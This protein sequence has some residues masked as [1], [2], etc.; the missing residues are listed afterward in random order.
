MPTQVQRT[1]CS[2]PP[3]ISKKTVIASFQEGTTTREFLESL[4]DW[5]IT[6]FLPESRTV[7]AAIY[8][9]HGI[10]HFS[11][12]LPEVPKNNLI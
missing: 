10:N 7:C 11:V 12:V 3:N 8:L 4:E 2:Q 6:S 1:A 5:E 9:P